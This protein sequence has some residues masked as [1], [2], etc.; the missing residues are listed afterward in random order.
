[1]LYATRR[2]VIYHF[3]SLFLCFFVAL[4]LLATPSFA[5]REGIDREPRV[6]GIIVRFKKP[7]A[8]GVKIS[9][10]LS[11]GL[12]LENKLLLENTFTFDV[13][14]EKMDGVI[15]D[16]E[17]DPDIQ[18]AEPNYILHAFE[19]PNDPDY[20]QQWGLPKIEADKAW[21]L[22]HGSSS[23]KVAILDTG[24]DKDHPD[25]SSDLSSKVD[26]W[27]NFSSSYSEDDLF[28]H[29]T[30]VAGIAAAIT[31]NSTGVAGTGYDTH[32][33]SVK[34]LGDDGSGATSWISNGI[35]WAADNGAQ[36]INMS[37][38][39]YDYSQ[40]LKDACDYAWGKGVV[41]V[42]SAGNCGQ[43]G[44]RCPSIN[45]ISYPASYE[46]VIAV[47]STTS[48][49]AKSSFSEYGDWVEVAAPGS[50]IYSTY[51]S[52]YTLMSGTSMASPFVA[53][54]AGLLF[55]AN[56]SL[57]ASQVRN[58]I[59]QNADEI[60]GTGTYWTY[61]RV[62][63]YK[64]VLAATE[65]VTLT[66]TP[67]SGATPT[68]TSVA[69]PTP[70]PPSGA[71]LTPTPVGGLTPTPTSVPAA[72]PLDGDYNSDGMVDDVDYYAWQEDFLE[73]LSNLACFEYWRR[74]SY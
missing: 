35:A 3:V 31:N 54:L 64:S 40:T 39:D 45:P 63:A 72:C 22:S 42:S 66:P 60:S 67:T 13:S 14:E 55:G 18:Y 2:Q 24:I 10:M 50:S 19:T 59:E 71:T 58:F 1:M 5:Q 20:D 11:K 21:D 70:T 52:G 25:L 69:T 48:T 53:G 33:L 41:V 34:V 37:L 26:D 56:P 36:V 12:E 28:G 7:E 74:N 68:P 27:V 15:E 32:L 44:Q 51:P 6:R 46:S 57:T 29:G 4:L 17:S 65:G 38:G 47:A 9:G 16:L 61:G 49:D 62:N 8:M 43:G 30:H 23:V 73:G